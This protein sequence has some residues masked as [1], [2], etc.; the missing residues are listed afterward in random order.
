MMD[1]MLLSARGTLVF[2]QEPFVLHQLDPGAPVLSGSAVGQRTARIVGY[3]LPTGETEDARA[4]E[5]E[6]ARR[7][8][9]RIAGDPAGFTLRMGGRETV[10]LAQRAPEFSAE[11]PLTG[12]D[13]A[14]F[15]IHA[16]SRD[17]DGCFT[18]DPIRFG[19]R[20]HSG[21]LAFPLAVTEQ[22]LF[23]SQAQSGVWSA[24]NPGDKEAGFTLR[25]QAEGGGI[26]SFTLSLGEASLTVHHLLSEGQSLCIDTRP[27]HKDVTAGGVS[28]LAET[29]WRS[30]FFS[31]PPGENTL[32]WRCTGTG[33]PVLGFALTPRYLTGGGYGHSDF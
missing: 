33:H 19:I 32:R 18:G 22:T 23:G 30:S 2:G 16:V 31:L 8:V 5:M 20:G 9:C 14:L 1:V 24:E 13:A 4:A 25:V 17:G 7:L 15:T 28:V 29:D 27:G 3:I 12:T 6:K 26:D 21:M 11:A 10:L